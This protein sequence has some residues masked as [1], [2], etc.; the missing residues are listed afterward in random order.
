MA[1]N[2]ELWREIYPSSFLEH[3]VDHSVL[4]ASRDKNDA[5]FALTQGELEGF[6]GIQLLS[7]NHTVLD[8]GDYRSTQ[9]DLGIPIVQGAMSRNRFTAI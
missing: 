3:S 1:D 4:Y 2:L 5:N 8:E 7:G 6:L 9:P